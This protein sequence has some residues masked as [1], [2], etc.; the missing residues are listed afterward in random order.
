MNETIYFSDGQNEHPRLP[1][2]LLVRGYWRIQSVRSV[3][4]RF[5]G[6]YKSRQAA[7]RAQQ[8]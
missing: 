4:E 6:P 8:G 7:E 2:T 5:F 1:G 3:V